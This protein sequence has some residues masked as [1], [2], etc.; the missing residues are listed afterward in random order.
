MKKAGTSVYQVKIFIEQVNWEIFEIFYFK[1][2]YFV[3]CLRKYL[4]ND[5]K[6]HVIE[7]LCFSFLAVKLYCF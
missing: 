6:N 3:N 4:K 1:I 5:H 7:H 2:D